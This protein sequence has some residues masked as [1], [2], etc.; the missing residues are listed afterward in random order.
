[1]IL[2]ITPDLQ[3]KLLEVSPYNGL[4]YGVLILLMVFAIYALWRSYIS[5]K[6]YNRARDT[7]LMEVLPLILDKLN[8]QESI[9]LNIEILNNNTKMVVEGHEILR[10][11]IDELVSII[12]QHQ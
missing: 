12:K 1:M 8:R 5:E 6:E 10:N 11:K 2:Q 9:P 4:A 7:K 3:N